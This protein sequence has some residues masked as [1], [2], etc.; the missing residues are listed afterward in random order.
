EILT[1]NDPK[2]LTGFIEKE[3]GIRQILTSSNPVVLRC[4]KLVEKT[5]YLL[6]LFGIKKRKE[7]FLPFIQNS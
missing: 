5:K 2:R 4:E 6:F 7:C 3:A 1:G